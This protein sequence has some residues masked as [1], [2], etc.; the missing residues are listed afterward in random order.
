MRHVESNNGVIATSFDGILPA[1]GP[2][3]LE[4]GTQ[5][6]YFGQSVQGGVRIGF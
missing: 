6:N 1:S 2:Y 5:Q 4:E 3:L